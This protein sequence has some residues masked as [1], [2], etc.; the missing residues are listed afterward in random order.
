VTLNPGERIGWYEI[1]SPVGSGGM[2]DVYKARDVRLE[3]AVALKV[4]RGQIGSPDER[5]RVLREARA[6]ATLQ[7]PNICVL[8]D[9]GSDG[10][11]D[12]LVFEFLDGENLAEK[13]QQGALK[14]DEVMA[15][16]RQIADALAAAHANGI[17]HGDLKPHNIMVVSG[18]C[19]VVDFGLAAN[20]RALS[21]ESTM[22]MRTAAFMGPIGTIPYMAPE[23]LSG[24]PVGF[25]VDVFAF[26]AILYEMLSGHRA[27]DGPTYATI[28]GS[29]LHCE[30]E[31]S[32][33][34]DDAVSPWLKK[35]VRDCLRR[36]P[37]ERPTARHI[38]RRLSDVNPAF[39]PDVRRRAPRP[40]RKLRLTVLPVSGVPDPTGVAVADLLASGIE[41]LQTVRVVRRS[42]SSELDINSSDSWKQIATDLRVD[43]LL[44]GNVRHGSS[45]I[46]A[47]I[48]LIDPFAA[49]Q[50]YARTFVQRSGDWLLMAGEITAALIPELGAVLKLNDAAIRTHASPAA[51]ELY[52]TGR[53]LW[54][55]RTR[56]SIERAAE[57]FRQAIDLAAAWALPHAGLG[58]CYLC[59][60]I[61]G[62]ADVRA[63]YERARACAYKA[64]GLDK[65]LGEPHATLGVVLWEADWNWRASEHEFETTIS[66]NPSYAPGYLWF[67]KQLMLRGQ[68]HGALHNLN[69]AWRLD[70][71]SLSVHLLLGQAW[72]AARHYDIARSH[73]E[74]LHRENPSWVLPLYFL[75]M[76]YLQSGRLE[77]ARATLNK[78][79]AA[80][81]E[82]RHTLVGVAEMY[83]KTGEKRLAK[84]T[85]DRL[86]SD[87]TPG[88]LSPCDVAEVLATFGEQEACIEWLLKAVDERSPDLAGLRVD[89]SYDVMR[90]NAQFK[91][92]VDLVFGD[93]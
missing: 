26:G 67:G 71:L 73:F 30:P 74:S 33:L 32:A 60:G 4:L 62:W 10:P 88:A 19:K 40:H 68:H 80:D 38:C 37:I 75:G 44:I 7:H 13:I 81:P 18:V 14:P 1:L 16:A 2:G 82:T 78:A 3:R 28:V 77:E 59:I 51:Q 5:D 92:I 41:R 54:A 76:T 48:R 89:P 90:E 36:N 56:E 85:L 34:N 50:P 6:C 29:I 25:A 55:K 65:T 79:A 12:Y 63:S 45:H 35:L 15:F 52:L 70:P 46:I 43:R 69:I 84:D 53:H 66:L 72:Y 20:I 47:D 64:I 87:A 31:W 42:G 8:H 58:D 9:I 21:N 17:L 83:W 23:R 86:M 61:A 57:C 24:K 49:R 91:E 27:F 39:K 11:H 22:T 93:A